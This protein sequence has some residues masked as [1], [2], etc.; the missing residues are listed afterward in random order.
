MTFDPQRLR[1]E[2]GIGELREEDADPDP[3][4]LFAQWLRQAEEA[5]LIEAN[6]MG[7]STVGI[8]G[9]PTSRT[10]LLKDFD[11]RGFVFATSYESVKGRDLALNPR[12]SLLFYWGS[13]ERQVRIM[14]LAE[15]T[16][17]AESD[18]IFGARTRD[19]RISAIA[20]PQSDVIESRQWLEART[21]TIRQALGPDEEPQRPAAWGGYRV[22]PESIEFWQ[23]RQNRL[24]DRLRYRLD[25][26]A[27][28][29]ERLAP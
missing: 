21:E 18:A 19:S 8:D 29:I 15:K 4:A 14:G 26:T 20:S 28:V 17:E 27:W 25:G 7:V 3:F 9:F 16:S 2:Y 1:R 11:R 10:V 5:R 6:A 13:L 24:H 12:V 23:G 22:V